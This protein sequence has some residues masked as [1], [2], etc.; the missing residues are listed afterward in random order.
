MAENT[1]Q[2][3]PEIG[4][5]NLVP[6]NVNDGPTPGNPTLAPMA[7]G[8]VTNT[9]VA[10]A[11][12]SVVHV[13]DITGDVKYSIALVSLKIGETL[14]AIRKAL[15]A[16]WAGVTSSPFADEVRAVIKTIK[17]EI[18]VAQKFIKSVVDKLKV[19]QD[20]IA[21]LQQLISYIKSL[22]ARLFNLLQQCLTEATASL[23]DAITNSKSI[24]ASQTA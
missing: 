10:K 22:P 16:L 9:S 24:V 15:S 12:A 17:A 19:I 21:K 6:L 11:N 7:R 4:N 20:V 1:I 13:C 23:A 14:Q 2:T 3:L 8:V 18:K 5:D